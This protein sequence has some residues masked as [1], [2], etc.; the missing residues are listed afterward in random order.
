MSAYAR[1]IGC[2]NRAL[3]VLRRGAAARNA[4][5]ST[6]A[7]AHARQ[8]RRPARPLR[9]R[10]G[11]ACRSLQCAM[12]QRAR[13]AQRRSV[14]RPV[15][16]PR[17]SAASKTED[18][19]VEP[20]TPRRGSSPI[21]AK[22]ARARRRCACAP[23]TAASSRSPI[24]R[25]AAGCDDLDAMC[26]ALCPN[27][28]VVGLHLSGRRR[29]RT[30]GLLDRPALHGQPQRAEIPAELRCDLHLPAA[31]PELGGRAGRRRSPARPG[32]QGRHHR[33][34]AEVAGDV[35]AEGRRQADPKAEAAKTRQERQGGNAPPTANAARGTDVNGVD[36]SLER[37]GRRRSAA[38]PPASPAASTSGAAPVAKDQGQTVEET[39]P[40]GVKRTRPDNR[41]S[42][43]ARPIS[44]SSAASSGPDSRPVKREPQ[45]VEQIAPL[46]AGGALERR[47]PGAP[48]LASQGSAAAGGRRAARKSASSTTGAIGAMDDAPPVRRVLESGQIAAH[49]VPERLGRRRRR[50]RAPRAGRRPRERRLVQRARRQR[51]QFGCVEARRGM[52]ELAEIESL[53]PVR[54]ARRSA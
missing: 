51:A 42:A 22:R 48:A 47:R 53:R 18:V 20:L 39:G 37:A 49:G 54:R 9:R 21:P 3:P 45:R 26:H 4:R 34:A 43:L 30:G 10:P 38:R 41:S 17:Q 28:D 44:G 8:S 23:A 12:R 6:A 31:R 16:Q 19:T 52:R 40:D 50:S 7:R 5:R 46:A 33:H 1:S 2:E 13:P 15:R 27:A 11:R 24:R 32:E 25:A 36:T 29:D 14:R 35:A